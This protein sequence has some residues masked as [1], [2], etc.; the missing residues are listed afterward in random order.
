MRVIINNIGDYAGS[1]LFENED[2]IPYDVSV[3]VAEYLVPEGQVYILP[4]EM[5]KLGAN[6]K[7]PRILREIKAYGWFMFY[8]DQWEEVG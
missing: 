7:S 8:E 6:L 3:E 5:A 2:E 4:S 1:G